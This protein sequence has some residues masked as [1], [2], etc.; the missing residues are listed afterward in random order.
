MERRWLGIQ[1]YPFV[2]VFVV[3][4]KFVANVV[5]HQ[6][7][8]SALVSSRSRTQVSG[9]IQLRIGFV[10]PEPS[11]K[12]SDPIPPIDFESI[13]SFLVKNSNGRDLHSVPAFEGIGTILSEEGGEDHGF[14]SSSDDSDDE[15]EPGTLTPY[16]P[17][18]IHSGISTPVNDPSDN[19]LSPPQAGRKG[20]FDNLGSSAS[21]SSAVAATPGGRSFMSRKSVSK[22]QKKSSKNWSYST[23]TDI[24]GVVMVEI[25]S[26]E[27]LPRLKNCW[28]LFFSLLSFEWLN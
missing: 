15:D 12:S 27:D 9:S 6:P 28:S 21:S 23:Q 17:A 18:L 13:Y 26:A 19:F 1:S 5:T 25:K 10:P 8:S 20:Y 24:L 3:L 11:P 22:K 14:D 7:I 16:T 2:S 4:I